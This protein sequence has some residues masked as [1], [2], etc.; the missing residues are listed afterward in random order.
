MFYLGLMLVLVGLGV[1]M[2]GSNIPGAILICIG[3]IPLLI[4]FLVIVTHLIVEGKMRKKH[5]EDKGQ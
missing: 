4:G 2:L 1:V 3:I 5:E